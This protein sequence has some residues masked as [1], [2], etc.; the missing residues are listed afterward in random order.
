MECYCYLRNV[1][2]LLADKKTPH[3]RRFGEPFKGPRIPFGAMVEYHPSSV[4]DQSRLD[5]FG[6]KV[7]L[8]YEFIAGRIWKGD[9]LGCGSGRIEKV[10]R[11]RNLS[12]KNQ[13]E[14]CE[15]RIHIPSCKWYSK[16]VR[17]RLPFLRTSSKAGT[18]RKERRSQR[19]TSRRTGRVST[20]R[21]T[22]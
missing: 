14:R 4:R 12:S 18:N 6:K 7:L 1:Q 10:G 20:D 17:K 3:D 19:R 16:V 13:R 2:D 21:I 5:Q 22:R 15:R 11:I 9:S 8:G